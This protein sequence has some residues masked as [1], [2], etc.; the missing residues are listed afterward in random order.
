[1]VHAFA[2]GGRGGNPAPIVLDAAGLDDAAMQRIAREHGLESGFVLPAPPGSGCDLQLRFWVPAHEMSMCGHAT[3]AAVWLLDRLAGERLTAMRVLTRSGV[4]EAR[5]HGTGDGRRVE[6]AQ[7]PGTV[8]PVPRGAVEPILD[9]LGLDPD[10][11]A[12]RPVRNASTSRVKTLVP[13]ADGAV[14]DGLAPDFARVEVVCDRARS[15]GLYPYAVT[16]PAAQV[17][18]ARQFPRSSG[19]PEDAATGIAAAAL[20]FGLLHDG[21]VDP[22][23]PV[24]VRQGR[25]MG[26]PSRIELRFRSE[27]GGVWMG[28]EVRLTRR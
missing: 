18:D 23:R 28:G 16:D 9:V 24:T 12:D 11:L 27:D 5:L 19:Y 2:D 10:A 15:T 20:A 7:P 1:M 25:A 17:V 4:V 3:L 6:I 22:A 13:V 26:R 14:L 21:L 8:E